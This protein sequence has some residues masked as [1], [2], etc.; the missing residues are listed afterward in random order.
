MSD[1]SQNSDVHLSVARRV[2]RFLTHYFSKLRG[3]G[4]GAIVGSWLFGG[5]ILSL[6]GQGGFR[7]LGFALLVLFVAN[8]L[9]LAY[10]Y[11]DDNAEPDGAANR[12]Q[13]GG[14]DS[15]RTPP[16]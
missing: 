4:G 6:G 15:N 5:I 1:H 2:H 9:F 10:W 8:Y 16:N 7:I 14:S 11:V 12:T 3:L 13:P